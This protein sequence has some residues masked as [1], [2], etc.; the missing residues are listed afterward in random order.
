MLTLR[1]FFPSVYI[2]IQEYIVCLVYQRAQQHGHATHSWVCLV[3]RLK[4]FRPAVDKSWRVIYYK[5]QGRQMV[6]LSIFSGNFVYVNNKKTLYVVIFNFH[7]NIFTLARQ[8]C[9]ASIQ[10]MPTAYYIRHKNWYKYF[11]NLTSRINR[12]P[13]KT[14]FKYQKWD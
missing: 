14:F 7:S 11:H 9:C 1:F 13:M 6:V 5:S 3:M 12:F 4:S 2:Y 8:K 10:V